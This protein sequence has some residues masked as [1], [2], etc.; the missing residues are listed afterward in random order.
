MTLQTLKNA[1]LVNYVNAG[2]NCDVMRVDLKWVPNH[3]VVSCRFIGHVRCRNA[4]ESAMRY[5]QENSCSSSIRKQF[6]G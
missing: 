3:I 6:H 1:Y 5:R 2:L 4:R